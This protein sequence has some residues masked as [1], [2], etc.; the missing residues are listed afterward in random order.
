MNRVNGYLH[1]PKLRA[2]LDAHF[3]R[4]VGA[5][6]DDETVNPALTAPE[7]ATKVPRTRDNLHD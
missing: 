1:L 5:D 4:N 2:A 3:A 6:C 7:A